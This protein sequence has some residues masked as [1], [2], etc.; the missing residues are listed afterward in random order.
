MY[1]DWYYFLISDIPSKFH[2]RLHA[3]NSFFNTFINQAQSEI[4]LIK[5]VW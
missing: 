5:S 2:N 3:S 1:L 4:S